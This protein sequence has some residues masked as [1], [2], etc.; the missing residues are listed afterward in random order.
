M[1]HTHPPAGVPPVQTSAPEHGAPGGAKDIEGPLVTDIDGCACLAVVGPGHA[2]LGGPGGPGG[3]C[4][5]V[6]TK[7][8]QAVP[9][10][11]S[12]AP[13]LSKRR[14]PGTTDRH[15]RAAIKLQ[16]SFPHEDLHCS[17]GCSPAPT[18]WVQAGRSSLHPLENGHM[19]CVPRH[20]IT[21][22][23]FEFWFQGRK[24]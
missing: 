24:K 4:A 2:A 7:T 10:T 20:C 21:C 5:P 15:C 13:A 19:F 22:G 1:N 14:A 3:M 23:G 8:S 11:G 12:Q 6:L 9:G 16:P 17:S 18:V